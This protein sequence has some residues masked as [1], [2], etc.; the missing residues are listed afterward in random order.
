AVLK[1]APNYIVD[2]ATQAVRK[3][4]AVG[5]LE[6]AARDAIMQAV[7]ALSSQALRVLAVAV[8][9]LPALPA[10]VPEGGEG[11]D[12]EAAFAEL[13]Q[14]L[15]FVGL[16][17]SIDPERD[18][19]RESIETARGAGVRTIMITGDYLATAVAIARDMH[20]LTSAD[21]PAAA[22]VDCEALRPGGAYLPAFDL[23]AITT[24][25]NVF[26]RARPED[27]LQIVRSLQRQGLVAAMTGDGVNDAPA[28]NEADIGIAMGITGTEV[29]KG[30]SG[31]ILADDNFTTIVTAIRK[32]RVIY[33]NIQKFLTYFLGTNAGQVI[34]IF[35]CVSVGLP[36]PLTPLSILFLNLSIDGLPA[37]CMSVEPG[38]ETIMLER[39]RPRKQPI[40]FGR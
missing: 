11:M 5:P 10:S 32:G 6:P 19:V 7:D 22:A 28:L 20:L 21:D 35:V 16:I 2:A 14:D 23:D 24:R 9:A 26:A 17:A 37:M 8:R 33:S 13:K 38:D 18:G 25:V 31:M 36:A 1:G 40:I 4:G 29:A 27:K 39:P 15:T 30:A 34:L 12:A 3:D